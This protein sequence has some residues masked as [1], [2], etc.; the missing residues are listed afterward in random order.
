MKVRSSNKYS[1]S[2][3]LKRYLASDLVFHLQAL[4]VGNM[5]ILKMTFMYLKTGFCVP[6]LLVAIVDPDGQVAAQMRV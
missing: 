3:F 1:I 6:L 5:S 4:W 2:C